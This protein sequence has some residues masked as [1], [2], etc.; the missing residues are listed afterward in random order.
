MLLNRHS[1]LDSGSS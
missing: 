1:E